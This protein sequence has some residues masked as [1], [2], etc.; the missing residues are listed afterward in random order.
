MPEDY[1]EHA[2]LIFDL[3]AVAFNVD[4]AHVFVFDVSGEV[5]LETVELLGDGVVGGSVF[6]AE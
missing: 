1:D 3:L 4:I 6:R 5:L 2:R